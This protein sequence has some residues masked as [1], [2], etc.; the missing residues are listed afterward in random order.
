MRFLAAHRVGLCDCSLII[1][2]VVAVRAE[3]RPL[4]AFGRNCSQ[5]HGVPGVFFEDARTLDDVLLDVVGQFTSEIPAGKYGDRDRGEGP[6][7]AYLAQA[8]GTFPLTVQ[9]KDADP[10]V[11]VPEDFAVAIKNVEHTDPDF[12]NGELDKDLWEDA[13]LTLVGARADGNGLS[14]IPADETEWTLHTDLGIFFPE[15]A[16]D[17]YY[18]SAD[19]FGHEWQGALTLDLDVTVPIGV[20]PGWYDVEI[21][22]EGIEQGYGA[23]YEDEHFYLQV[24]PEPCTAA[25]LASGL[26]LALMR[27]R[28][29]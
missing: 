21:S 16:G 9:V 7:Q 2:A 6:L 28:R 18:T 13:A 24:V 27:R 3:A 26:G 23:F 25:L 19:T 10:G 12:Q 17:E 8:G 4:G 22:I 14:S 5:C 29:V 1:V 11:I 15:T 20:L